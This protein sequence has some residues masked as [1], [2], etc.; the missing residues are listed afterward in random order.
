MFEKNYSG[1][2][3]DVRTSVVGISVLDKGI[4]S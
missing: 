4:V 3:V 1:E 2:T